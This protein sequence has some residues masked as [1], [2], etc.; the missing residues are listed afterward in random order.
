MNLLIETLPNGDVTMGAENARD[1]QMLQEK[2]K[3]LELDLMEA[4]FQYD[5]ILAQRI[6]KEKLRIKDEIERLSK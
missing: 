1:I 3:D 2:H 4:D 6:K 5:E